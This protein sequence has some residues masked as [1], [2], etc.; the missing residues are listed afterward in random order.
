MIERCNYCGKVHETGDGE[1]FYGSVVRVC[2][3]HPRDSPM[4]TFIDINAFKKAFV[5]AYKMNR[6][7]RNFLILTSQKDDSS[8]KGLSHLVANAT[9]QPTLCQ[10]CG[11]TYDPSKIHPCITH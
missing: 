3:E 2:P 9:I 10:L 6:S 11:Q 4:F 7:P 5:D 8:P 1:M